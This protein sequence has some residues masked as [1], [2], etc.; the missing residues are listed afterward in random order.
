MDAAK[1]KEKK[2][3]HKKIRKENR[4]KKNL[5]ESTTPIKERIIHLKSAILRKSYLMCDISGGNNGEI[6]N[7]TFK[8]N[9]DHFTCQI[10]CHID[11]VKW[12][13]DKN[14][15][16]FTDIP[17]YRGEFGGIDK[18]MIHFNFRS[19]IDGIYWIQK[20]GA[21]RYITF[22]EDVDSEGKKCLKSIWYNEKTDNIIEARIG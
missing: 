12:L 11:Q 21:Y 20:H 4:K 9:D 6:A 15:K 8:L 19:F 13:K 7:V 18:G 17:Q 3:L 5:P 14:E 2:E 10:G 16:M 22:K 1:K